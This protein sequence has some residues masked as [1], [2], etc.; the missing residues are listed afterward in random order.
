M[1]DNIP[2][3]QAHLFEPQG[4]DLLLLVERKGVTVPAFDGRPRK[5]SLET[6]S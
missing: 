4:I 1:C 2:T 5:S 3:Q 6:S